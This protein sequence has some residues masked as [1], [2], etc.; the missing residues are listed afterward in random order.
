MNKFD[1]RQEVA[2]MTKED[3]VRVGIAL[4]ALEHDPNHQRA[5]DLI[6]RAMDKYEEEIIR[7]RAANGRLRNKNRNYRTGIK[8]LQRAHEATLHRERVA[9][10]TNGQLKQIIEQGAV[11]GVDFGNE[12]PEAPYTPIRFN[13]D[14]AYAQP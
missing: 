9:Q 10:E 11:C 2:E 5:S 8:N 6:V 14:M 13:N 12:Q 1:I 7:L 3:I 4:A